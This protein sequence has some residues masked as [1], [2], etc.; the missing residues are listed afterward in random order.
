MAGEA[1]ERIVVCVGPGPRAERLVRTASRMAAALGADW[2]AISVDTPGHAHLPDRARDWVAEHLRLAESLGARVVHLSGESVSRTLIGYAREHGATRIL[3]GKPTHARWRNLFRGSL[4][5]DLARESGGIEVY[6]TS[7]DEAADT[8]RR[9]P[10]SAARRSPLTSYLWSVV[11]VGLASLVATPLAVGHFPTW[12]LALVFLLGTVVVATR[13]GRGPAILAAT[14]G[15]IVFDFVFVPPYFGFVPHDDSYVTTFIMMI[16]VGVTVSTLANRVRE[17][18]ALARSHEQWAMTLHALSRDLAEARDVRAVVASATRHLEAALTGATVVLLPGPRG[19]LVAETSVGPGFPLEPA[20]T[21]AARSVFERG[22]A[23]GRGTDV[24]PQVSSFWF[25]LQTSERTLGVLGFRPAADGGRDTTRLPML[26]ALAHQVSGALERALLADEAKAT[27]L[28]ART[29]ELR[30]ALLSSV[31]HDLRTPLAAVMGSASTLLED[32]GLL[33]NTQRI[34][35]TRTI[36][37]ETERLNR[38]VTNLL[39]MT[40]VESKGFE[41][42]REWVPLEETVGAALER[43]RARLAGRP[44]LN[45]LPADPPLVPIDAVLLEQVFVNLLE[46]AVRY[47]PPGTPLEIDARRDGDR[48]IVEVRDSGPGLPAGLEERVFEKF[49]RA[50]GA[51]AGG[52]GLGLTICRGIVAAHGG[53]IVAA[54]RPEGGAVFRLTLPLLGGPPALREEA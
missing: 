44:I 39:A 24:Q 46:N 42:R 25:P 28:R 14:L 11:I 12:D 5:D 43:L 40:R 51:P 20:E 6:V 50:P 13:F 30:N 26:E 45:Q 53:A 23:A 9:P 3:V 7:G 31:S 19:E 32:R 34:D 21:V 10:R 17:Q 2:T 52:S 49:F 18:A 4:I 47:T 1:S 35:L 29:E 37:E 36:Y 8:S 54:S 33:S 22:S 41:L 38:L 48:V 15:V 16:V 27:E